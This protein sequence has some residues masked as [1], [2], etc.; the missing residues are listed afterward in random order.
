MNTVVNNPLLETWNTPYELPPFGAVRPE[1]FAPA[2]EL[3]FAQHK[4]EI[5]AIASDRL[6]PTF[7][8][9]LVAFDRAGSLLSRVSDLF[10]NLT[11]AATN[12]ALQ[13]V[14][15]DLAPKSAAHDSAIFM[16]AGLFARIDALVANRES[17][18]LS[19]EQERLLDRVHLD[20]VRSG[21]KF[22]PD[23]KKRYAEI[24]QRL[25][26]LT[27]QFS[28]N[29][30]G[31]E[32]TWQILLKTESDLAG[33]PPFLR[34]AAKSAATARGVSD[35]HVITL[36]RSLVMPFI[37]F[38]ERRDLR[39]QAYNAWVS[40]GE[41]AGPTDNRGIAKDILQ[42]RKEQA[43]LHGFANYADY[44]LSDSMAKKPAAVAELLGKVWEPAKARVASELAALEAMRLSHGSNDPVA[45]W[46]W[47]FY[48]EKVRKARY[49]LDDAETKPYFELNAMVASMFDCAGKLFGLKFVEKTGVPLYHPDVRLFE[50]FDASN[51]LSGIFLSDNFA[52][53][54]K[55][56]GAWMSLYRYQSCRTESERVI[57]IVANHNNFAKA[58]E[59]QATLLTLDDLRTLFHEFGHGLH[60]LLSNV[61]YKRLACTQVLQDYV[62]LPSQLYE[63]WAMDPDVLA[64]HAR[65]FQTGEAMPKSLLD[66]IRSAELFNAGYEA[67][68]YTSSALIDMAAHSLTDYSNFDLTQFERDQLVKLG[69]PKEILPRHRLPHF[70]HLFSGNY[71]AAGYYVYMWAE[72]LDADAFDAFKEAGDVFDKS[73]AARL[74]KFVYGAGNSIEPREG[75]AAF[76]GRDAVVEPMLRGRGL[77]AESAN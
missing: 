13:A 41:H 1:Q 38:S 39:E 17:L 72:V 70:G 68:E 44:A 47:R 20:F 50:V 2:F 36:S 29:V 58:P 69:A 30:L 9:T 8:N 60:G 21:A 77:L 25:A 56:G 31:D 35:G 42:L 4:T 49:D 28:Q 74:Q 46:D 5:D 32:N 34:D 23:A 10:S 18:G 67:V 73:T 14:Q 22:A 19:K 6:A 52:R 3:A 45:A 33:L 75:Y 11:S 61:R 24:M 66:R 53:Q 27:T 43:V 26:E 51:V 55:N 57:P 12:D 71:Y 76:R 62:E 37:T 59:G 64:K 40:R 48:S 15:R 16:H 65:H 54:G 7:E 63:H